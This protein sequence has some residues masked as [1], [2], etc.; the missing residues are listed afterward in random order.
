MRW[1]ELGAKKQRKI[2]NSR[3][4][5]DEY[6]FSHEILNSWPREKEEA[7]S[8]GFL[9]CE[10]RGGW[11]ANN[12]AFSAAIDAAQLS[13]DKTHHQ[14]GW[15]C[16]WICAMNVLRRPINCGNLRGCG[17]PWQSSW[18][19]GLDIVHSNSAFNPLKKWL[20][21]VISWDNLKLELKQCQWWGRFH[22]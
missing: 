20:P 19:T 11:P 1:W 12:C 10:D 16:W 7:N 8:Q 17:G 4:L 2:E 5:M 18:S 13:S 6:I 14:S 3:Q 22:L 15:A 21:E 9:Y